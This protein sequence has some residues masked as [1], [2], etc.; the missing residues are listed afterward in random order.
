VGIGDYLVSEEAEFDVSSSITGPAAAEARTVTLYGADTPQAAGSPARGS[1][2]AALD[3][4]PGQSAR[5]VDEVSVPLDAEN[6]AQRQ[7]VSPMIWVSFSDTGDLDTDRD[8]LPDTA[9]D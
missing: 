7:S 4:G 9:E 8:G 5:V 6:F 1:T 3:L 2:V